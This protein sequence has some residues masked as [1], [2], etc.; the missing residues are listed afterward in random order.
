MK[1]CTKFVVLLS[2]LAPSAFAD[3]FAI[4]LG[5]ADPFAVLAGS[6]VTNTGPT[7]IN[8]NLGV[9]PGTAITGF[10]PGTVTGTMH[11]ADA[12]AQQAQIDLTTAY[13]TAA[14]LPCS[15]N[16]SGQ[17][18][19]GLTLLPGVYCFNSSAQLT[20]MLTLNALGNPNSLLYS[21]SGA[22]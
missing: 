2:V 8:G 4:N 11:S 1:L 12:V 3:P 19:G 5:A 14:G 6:T 22:R 10:P 7:V 16:L 20:G 17:N 21:R 18:L 15:T 13:N 9:W